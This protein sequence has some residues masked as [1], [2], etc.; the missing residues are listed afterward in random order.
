MADLQKA[1]AGQSVSDETV[2]QYRAAKVFLTL[3]WF[4]AILLVLSFTQLYVF[5]LQPGARV[6]LVEIVGAVMA[7]IGT[8][9]WIS[10][11]NAYYAIDFP[12]KRRVEF[13]AT[14]VAGAGFVF[15]GLFFLALF[16]AWRGVEFL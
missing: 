14:V 3:E 16:L 2:A 4:G 1:R 15:W 8:L 9:L 11:R 10:A 7:I 6:L 12:W 5:G 13:F